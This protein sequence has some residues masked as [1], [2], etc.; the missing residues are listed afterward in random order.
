MSGVDRMWTQVTAGGLEQVVSPGGG[1]EGGLGQ[2]LPSTLPFL[3]QVRAGSGQAGWV[4]CAVPF[5]LRVASDVYPLSD[6]SAPG[7]SSGPP[8]VSTPQPEGRVT[9][10]LVLKAGAQCGA[11]RNR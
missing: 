8:E 5:V 10:P 4:L 6:H 9:S 7:P 1:E 2:K 3:A 11:Q